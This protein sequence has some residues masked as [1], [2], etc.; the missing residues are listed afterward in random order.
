MLLS[1][2]LFAFIKTGD[3]EGICENSFAVLNN[4]EPNQNRY[5][6]IGQAGNSWDLRVVI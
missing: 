3:V 2:I 4:R 5:M 6:L 1:C